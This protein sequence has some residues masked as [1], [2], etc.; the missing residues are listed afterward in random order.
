MLFTC[1]KV[2]NESQHDIW[3]HELI[4]PIC[5]MVTLRICVT[6]IHITLHVHM[7]MYRTLCVVFL[8]SDL[9]L[10]IRM[11]P[12][13]RYYHCLTQFVS[14]SSYSSNNNSGVLWCIHC[15]QQQ[16]VTEFSFF[17]LLILILW[18]ISYDDHLVCEIDLSMIFQFENS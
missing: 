2:I 18:Q 13:Y 6:Q 4:H 8:N 15:H 14:T 10:V 11:S 3:C 12:S 5:M 16:I 7:Y 17:T 1:K 9:S